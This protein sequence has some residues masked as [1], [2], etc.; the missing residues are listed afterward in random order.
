MKT[1]V[2]ARTLASACSGRRLAL[3]GAAAEAGV[4]R[5]W[6]NKAGAMAARLDGLAGLPQR[7]GDARLTAV[8]SLTTLSAITGDQGIP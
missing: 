6:T 8:L 3:L 1:E 2:A 4:R 5:H 7:L